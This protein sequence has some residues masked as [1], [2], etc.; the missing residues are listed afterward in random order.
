MHPLGT[1]VND[2]GSCARASHDA[3]DSSDLFCGCSGLKG[4]FH[5]EP[6]HLHVRGCTH[7]QGR[8]MS[9]HCSQDGI[10]GDDDALYDMAMTTITSIFCAQ[11]YRAMCDGRSGSRHRQGYCAGG[12]TGGQGSLAQAHLASL[13]T[14]GFTGAERKMPALQHGAHRDSSLGRLQ[15]SQAAIDRYKMCRVR[16][17]ME[18]TSSSPSCSLLY[19]WARCVAASA[20]DMGATLSVLTLQAMDASC[21]AADAAAG[22]AAPVCAAAGMTALVWNPPCQVQT[23]KVFTGGSRCDA[24]GTFADIIMQSRVGM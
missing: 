10:A 21:A 14:Y 7:V 19:A 5:L 15:P 6:S 2:D 9:R 20:V 16:A 17:M 13:A 4:M 8:L 24:A 18:L 3:C 22:P 1:P 12:S 23:D 11:W